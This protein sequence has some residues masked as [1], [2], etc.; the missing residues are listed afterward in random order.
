MRKMG[1][2]DR[3]FKMVQHVIGI[4][5]DAVLDSIDPRGKQSCRAHATEY[6]HF[7]LAPDSIPA[8]AGHGCVQRHATGRRAYASL[9]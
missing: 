8:V 9:F 6:D 5:N 4:R 1:C 3:P 7:G 2:R